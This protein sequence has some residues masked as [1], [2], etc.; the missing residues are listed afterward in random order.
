M[1]QLIVRVP[2]GCGQQALEIARS[3]KGAN[4]A[5]F[6]AA[7]EEQ[8]VDLL[9][10]HVSN[11]RI[12]GLL[13]ELQQLPD[14][15]VSLI[16]EGVIV[17]RPPASEAADQVT[18]VEPRSTVEVFLGGLQSVGSWKGFL[19]YAVAAGFVVWIGL[20]TNTIYLLTAAMLI[21]PF[22]G[23]AMNA[24]LA[25]ARGDR[26]LL[27]RSLLRYTAALLVSILVAFGMSFIMRQEVAT[28]QMVSTSFIS[29][30][31]VLLPLVAGAAGALNLCQSS[32]SSLVSGAATGMLVAA[33]LAPPAGLVGMASAMGE[34]DMVKS[35]AFV[36]LLQIV[37]INLS[38]AVMF[39]LFGL[40]SKGVRYDRGERWVSIAAWIG[41]AFLLA[42]L[43]IW[44]LSDAPSL[45]HSTQAQRAAA[46]VQ[47]VVNESGIAKLVE[48]EAR[49]T[50]AD[51]EGQNSLLVELYV[52][53][54][55]VLAPEEIREQLLQ[56]IRSRLS[57]EFDVTPLVTI[58]VFNL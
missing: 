25:T 27:G 32:R 38:G 7:G 24:A 39:R 12:D 3:H 31:A 37:G 2:K 42:A 57:A 26:W 49:F 8:S 16:P 17:L 28:E 35:G 34:W 52:Q 29:S 23:P 1:R 33:S 58:T 47:Q 22:A 30:V 54:D 45:Q 46:T 6:E 41:S 18:D 19:G 5:C 44:Q 40:S 48:A 56:A 21:A 43:L 10:V 4:L 36:L 9:L 15:H 50:R 20:F 51:I 14:L 13:D 55:G 53:S 11:S